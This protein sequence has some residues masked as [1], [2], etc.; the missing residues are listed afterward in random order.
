MPCQAAPQVLCLML[1]PL[2][3]TNV[4]SYQEDKHKL[5]F[6]DGRGIT[7]KAHLFRRA[8]FTLVP[9]PGQA[10]QLQ[11]GPPRG[12][13]AEPAP[14]A[15]G[16]WGR[17]NARTTLPIPEVPLYLPRERYQESLD[18]SIL[19]E[20]LSSLQTPRWFFMAKVELWA[21]CLRQTKASTGASGN[22]RES[23]SGAGTA[24]VFVIQGSREENT[25]CCSKKFWT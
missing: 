5:F 12:Y 20:I 11:R 3:P 22:G 17:A 4:W 9:W 24:R 18:G 1:C 8:C 10:E 15:V 21:K 7:L 23:S 13:G 14:P 16:G 25:D 2:N 19:V 6:S